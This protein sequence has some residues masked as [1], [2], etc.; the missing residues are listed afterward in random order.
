LNHQN[1]QQHRFRVSGGLELLVRTFSPDVPDPAR[2]IL[3]VHGGGEHGGRYEHVAERLVSRGWRVVVPDQRGHG[4]SEGP[5]ADVTSV[6]EYLDDL[7]QIAGE[8]CGPS[9]PVVFGHS[10]GGLLAVRLAETGFGARALVL[11]APLLGLLVPIPRWKLW[12]G[13]RLARVAPW[14]RFRMGLDPSNM[15]R[16]P[17]FLARRRA[18]VLIQKRVTI[19][20]FYAMQAA[21][22]LAHR[23][24][25][26]IGCPVLAVQGLDDHTV[27][28]AALREWFES[29]RSPKKLLLELPGRVHELMFESDWRD[30]VDRIADW[31][32]KLD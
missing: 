32:E 29:V 15:T 31:L 23:E 14:V 11:S 26:Q 5:R 24:V 28:P 13:Q 1:C 12:L 18:D 19:R 4:G 8:F 6:N 20:W 22:V 2:T 7:R 16:D 10:F 17:E 21:L 25:E 3:H 9:P 30:T 27:D